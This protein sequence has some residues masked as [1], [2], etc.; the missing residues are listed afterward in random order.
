VDVHR[1][2]YSGMPAGGFFVGNTTGWLFGGT[3][4]EYLR[5]VLAV[6]GG[7]LRRRLCV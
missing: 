2:A 7:T 3:A 4:P 6:I 1:S 5:R